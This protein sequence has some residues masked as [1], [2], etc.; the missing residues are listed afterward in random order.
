MHKQTKIKQSRKNLVCVSGDRTDCSIIQN[1]LMLETS[2]QI[3]K[4]CGSQASGHMGQKH[5][6]GRS[7]WLIKDLKDEAYLACSGD[8][9]K[10]SIARVL[11]A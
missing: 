10:V 3:G 5:I 7:S 1:G 11:Q 4:R 8:R 6:L 2:E 9:K